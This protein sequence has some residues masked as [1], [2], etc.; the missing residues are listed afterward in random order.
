MGRLLETGRFD[1]LALS[2]SPQTGLGGGIFATAQPVRERIVGGLLE[3]A[4]AHGVQ[5]LRSR[6][7]GPGCEGDFAWM[8]PRQPRTLF[9]FNDN[10]EES[11]AHGHDPAN[12]HG[13]APAGGPGLSGGGR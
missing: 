7:E 10:E 5:V 13:A 9:V 12:P 6:Y 8:L 11:A 4:R 3:V 2:W 1:T